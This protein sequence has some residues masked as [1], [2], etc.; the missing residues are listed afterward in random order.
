MD[1][2][3]CHHHFS[4]FKVENRMIRLSQR[5]VV[6]QTK[7][8]AFHAITTDYQAPAAI[9]IAAASVEAVRVAVGVVILAILSIS[10]Y[11]LLSSLI[12]IAVALLLWLSISIIAIALS[13]R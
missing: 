9:I 11:L 12:G 7:G 13:N 4:R 6:V 8:T 5:S 2:R 3:T 10:S 1:V